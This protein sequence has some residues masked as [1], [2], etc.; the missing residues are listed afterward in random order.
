MGAVG[1]DWKCHV[2]NRDKSGLSIV[3]TKL[4]RTGI[5]P[6][7]IS[8]FNLLSPLLAKVVHAWWRHQMEPFSAS[9]A[10]CAGNSPVPGEF[11]A[12]RPVT[13]SF[14]IFFDLRLNKRMSKQPW[15]WWFETLSCP[16]WR[17]CNV[18]SWSVCYWCTIY[19]TRQLI[20]S[21]TVCDLSYWILLYFY[22]IGIDKP[23][24][25]SSVLFLFLSHFSSAS[26]ALNSSA[27]CAWRDVLKD[28][29]P[30]ISEYRAAVANKILSNDYN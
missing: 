6:L 20:Y 16:L 27:A 12:Q 19:S 13:R 22:N 1:W 28:F 26:S 30:G 17:H 11:P 7:H 3:T 21:H 8:Y 25:F 10:I 24:Y 23:Y 18:R 5:S 29:F 9:L 4:S 2:C 14:E 15:G